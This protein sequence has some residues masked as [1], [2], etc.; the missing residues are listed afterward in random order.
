MKKSGSFIINYGNGLFDLAD[1]SVSWAYCKENLCQERAKE[2]IDQLYKIICSDVSSSLKEGISRSLIFFSVY[3]ECENYVNQTVKKILPYIDFCTRCR[4]LRPYLNALC[5]AAPNVLCE[6]FSSTVAKYEGTN[7]SNDEDCKIIIEGLLYGG[8]VDR[9]LMFESSAAECTKTLFKLY[10]L[11]F[12]SKNRENI[13]DILIRIFWEHNIVALKA[14]HKIQLTKYL[15]SKYDFFWD[16]IYDNI[17]NPSLIYSNYNSYGRCFDRFDYTDNNIYDLRVCYVEILSGSKCTSVEKCIKMIILSETLSDDYFNKIMGEVCRFIGTLCDKDK[18]KIKRK[19]RCV[20]SRHQEHFDCDRAMPKNRIKEMQKF[21]ESISFQNNAYDF[22]YLSQTEEYPLYTPPI[23]YDSEDE[24]LIVFYEKMDNILKF[25]F[26]RFKASNVNLEE[27]LTLIENDNQ[28]QIGTSIGRYYSNGK[29]D[30]AVLKQML[31]S[32]CS[33]KIIIDYIL[34]CEKNSVDAKNKSL[35]ISK[36]CGRDDIV[37]LILLSMPFNDNLINCLDGQS[38]T[39]IRDYW[40][41]SGFADM[42]PDDRNFLL[43]IHNQIK[44]NNYYCALYSLYHHFNKLNIEDVI[45]CLEI[46]STNIQNKRHEVNANEKWI[47]NKLVAKFDDELVNNLNL[48]NRV[49]NIEIRLIGVI[50][51]TVLKI[52]Q[53]LLS[54]DPTFFSNIVYLATTKTHES[55][56]LYFKKTRKWHFC[57]GA[58]N[59][60]IHKKILTNWIKVFSEMLRKQGKTDQISSYLG[61]LFVYSPIGNDGHFPHELIRDTIEEIADDQFYDAYFCEVYNQRGFHVITDGDSD[62][63]LA[64]KYKKE[65][66][67][68]KCIYPKTAKIYEKLSEAYEKSGK[69]IRMDAELTLF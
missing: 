15:A 40:K 4:V 39:V 67:H 65:A 32:N 63:S 24:G 12:S 42:R 69:K 8:V 34:E 41:R 60:T 27:Y 25:E 16:I 14:E 61:N 29:F 45:S 52:L 48:Y 64:E 19:V 22:L 38:E 21:C 7:G 30:E 46:I 17:M 9:L 36:Q 26:S 57:P 10:S 28:S 47:L 49:A 3:F 44:Y 59:G 58:C 20:I 62:L 31:D 37:S 55:F 35:Q 54:T 51:F 6:Y 2:Y 43:Y 66:N 11:E 53:N 13:Y 18:E 5:E 1:R 33:K 56:N 50:D 23:K 68:L